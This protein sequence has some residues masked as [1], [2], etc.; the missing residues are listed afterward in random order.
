MQTGWSV[1][2]VRNSSLELLLRSGTCGTGSHRN[3]GHALPGSPQSKHQRFLQWYKE[4][5]YSYLREYKEKKTSLTSQQPH[6]KAAVPFHCSPAFLPA[7]SSAVNGRSW[8]CILLQ[9]AEPVMP[10]KEFLLLQ[11]GQK[12]HPLS[13]LAEGQPGF[14]LSLLLFLQL[15][16]HFHFPLVRP[17]DPPW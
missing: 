2:E 5:R 12:A 7:H 15:P 16:G 13:F 4:V 6:H 17:E 9:K 8:R 10:R 1:L 3:E 11:P 14:H